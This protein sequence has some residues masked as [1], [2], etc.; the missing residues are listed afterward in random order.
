MTRLPCF[1][2]DWRVTTM[3]ETLNVKMRDTRGTRHARRTRRQGGIPAI[4][5]GHGE[6]NH[7]LTVVADEM[8]A[9]VRRGG[10]VVEL[11]G[12]VN[13][14]A[15]IR[16]LHWDTYGLEV[17]HVDFTRISEH[18]RVEVK[19]AVELRG[20]AVGVKD[21][22]IVTHFVHEIEIECEALSIPDRIEVN[23]N[24]LKI[25]ASVTAGDLHLPPGVK[26][27]SDPEAVVVQCV[28]A[29]EEEEEAVAAPGAAE[30]EVI[31]R[32]AE[33]AEEG[34]QD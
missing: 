34:S 1:Q 8:A 25:G 4:L 32:K 6:A 18:E 11:R 12:A 31:G 27:I 14:K 9:V 7:S 16:A 28:E 13:E 20:Q 5:Y 17:L 15:F 22:G 26:L 10:R 19:I 24:E 33:E 23:I 3:A 29:R 2:D 21:G 30:P